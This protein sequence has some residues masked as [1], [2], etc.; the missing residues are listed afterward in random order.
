MRR[1]DTKV[2]RF[3]WLRIDVFI[4][5]EY[6]KFSGH[7]HGDEEQKAYFILCGKLALMVG[8]IYL[9]WLFES[10]LALFGKRNGLFVIIS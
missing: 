1:K 2:S 6:K 3:C 7:D 5:N 9:F 4:R 8:I 10:V